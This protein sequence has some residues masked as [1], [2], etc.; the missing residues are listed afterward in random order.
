M[1]ALDILVRRYLLITCAVWGW[2]ADPLGC[3]TLPGSLL[4]KQLGFC[5]VPHAWAQTLGRSQCA[6]EKRQCG[7]FQLPV[8]VV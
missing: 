5:C 2:D 1:A 8:R 4:R 7:K 6:R 3:H